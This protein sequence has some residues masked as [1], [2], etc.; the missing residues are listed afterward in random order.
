MTKTH[1]DIEGFFDYQYLYAP[2]ADGVPEGATVVEI[3]S[4]FGQSMA[5]L[6]QRLKARGWEGRLFAVDS[7]AGEINQPAHE[8]IVAAHGG[9]IRAKFDENMRECGVDDMVRVIQGDSA[10]SAL[11]FEDGSCDFVFL[12]AAHEYDAVLRDLLAWIPKIKPGGIMA[13][14]DYPHGGVHQ[15]VLECFGSSGYEVF[16]ACWIKRFPPEITPAQWREGIRLG[17]I[18]AARKRSQREAPASP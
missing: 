3:G 1:A 2:V 5:F 8:A 4:W 11:M 10:A 17:A 12:D 7:F 13:G 16:N 15:A 14:H 18:E 9:S 6:A